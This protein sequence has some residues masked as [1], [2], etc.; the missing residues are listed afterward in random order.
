MEEFPPPRSGKEARNDLVSEL[1]RHVGSVLRYP[2]MWV[3]PYDKTWTPTPGERDPHVEIN[4]E[5]VQRDID[6]ESVISDLPRK[7]RE[8]LKSVLATL[9]RRFC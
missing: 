9:I 1:K 4:I 2:D 8:Y 6:E 5:D 3:I 7:H